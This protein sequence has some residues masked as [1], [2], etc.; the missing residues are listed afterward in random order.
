MAIAAVAA[1]CGGGGGDDAP[2]PR[3][4]PKALFV[5][6]ADRICADSLARTARLAGPDRALTDVEEAFEAVTNAD[7]RSTRAARRYGMRI[8]SED[9]EERPLPAPEDLP[10][11]GPVF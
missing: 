10:P 11:Q 9:E 3:R 1:G 5:A 8:C 6:G 7:D 4:T 2:E